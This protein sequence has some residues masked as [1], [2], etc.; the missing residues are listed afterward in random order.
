VDRARFAPTG[1]RSSIGSPMTLRMRPS[2]SGP[3]GTDDLRA[4]VGHFLAAGQTVGRVHRDGAH[5]VLAEVLRNF[6]NERLPLLLVS[7]AFRIA[8]QRRRRSRRR[9]RR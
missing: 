8:G 7:S 2:V 6:E 9:R 4:G 1:P 3:T 5:G